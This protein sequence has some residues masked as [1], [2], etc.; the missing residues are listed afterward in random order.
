[1]EI[2]WDAGIKVNNDTNEKSCLSEILKGAKGA[3]QCMNVGK[4]VSYKQS[5]ILLHLKKC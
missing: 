2:I 4:S 5:G 1:M 3:A